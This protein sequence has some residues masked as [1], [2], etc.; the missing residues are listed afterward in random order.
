MANK[1]NAMSYDAET[2]EFTPDIQPVRYRFYEK[3]SERLASAHTPLDNI[4]IVWD[5]L[6]NES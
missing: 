3:D 1:L 2:G 4:R 6:P 5:K